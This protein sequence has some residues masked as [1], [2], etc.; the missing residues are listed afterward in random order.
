MK[1]EQEKQKKIEKYKYPLVLAYITLG[2]ILMVIDPS[3]ISSHFGFI[4]A[5]SG[6][7]W[8]IVRF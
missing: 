6:A 1:K 2:L 5:F 8:W 3:G 4:V 7:A